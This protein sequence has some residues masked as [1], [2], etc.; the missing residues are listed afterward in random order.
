[1]IISQTYKGIIYNKKTAKHIHTTIN[2]IER[3]GIKIKASKESIN[4]LDI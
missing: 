4:E 3:K 2:V 1:M